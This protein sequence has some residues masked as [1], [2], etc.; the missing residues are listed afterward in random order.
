MPNRP[1]LAAFP[2][3][4]MDQLCLSG[5]MTLRQWIETAA[6][7][8]IEG[9]EFYFGFLDLKDQKRWPEA[10][11]IA[12]D[13]GLAIPMMCCSPDFTHPDHHFRQQ[14][15]DLERKM[16]DLTA[17]MGGQYCRV[18]SGQRRPEVSRSD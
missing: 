11:K 2:K 13:N 16:I 3:A 8:D 17:A 1:K 18:L 6:E 9:L 10:R 15:I 7:L 4:F 12:D 5:K 14:Q